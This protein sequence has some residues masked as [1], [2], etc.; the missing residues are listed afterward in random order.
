MNFF[1]HFHWDHVQGIPHFPPLYDGSA[2]IAM[3]S[4]IEARLEQIMAAQ[5]A[6][7]ITRCRGAIYPRAG[8]TTQ[9][10]P[11]SCASGPLPS[12][13]SPLVIRADAAATASNPL[14][15]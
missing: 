10:A 3:H 11:A 13:P 6:S 14:A 9:S 8:S 12:F 2:N 5:G 7:L 1:T 15:Q 4:G